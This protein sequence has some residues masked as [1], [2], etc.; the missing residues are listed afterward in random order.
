V[1]LSMLYVER[2]R[3]HMPLV[4]TVISLLVLAVFVALSFT[5]WLIETNTSIPAVQETKSVH[6]PQTSG[7]ATNVSVVESD[8]YGMDPWVMHGREF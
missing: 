3:T 1:T 7:S 2:A 5:S 6:V 4:C 8:P